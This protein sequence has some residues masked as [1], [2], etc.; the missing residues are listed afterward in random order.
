LALSR[1]NLP[2]HLRD[3]YAGF[4]EKVLQDAGRPISASTARLTESELALRI[5]GQGKSASLTGLAAEACPGDYL[6]FAQP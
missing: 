1:E 4:R 3:E 6:T 5:A 2:A